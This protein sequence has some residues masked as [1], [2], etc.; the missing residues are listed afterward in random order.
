M[1]LPKNRVK[2]MHLM[3]R[4]SFK[5]LLFDSLMIQIVVARYN[6]DV[7]WTRQ[8]PNVIIYNKGDPLEGYN[9]VI[10]GVPNVGRRTYVL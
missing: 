4:L 1:H 10:E 6:E 9:N 7:E 3:K 5:L 2:K 8:F